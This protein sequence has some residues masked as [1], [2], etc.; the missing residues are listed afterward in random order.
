MWTP[1]SVSRWIF[2]LT[3]AVVLFVSATQANTPGISLSCC[4]SHESTKIRRIKRCFEQ[5]PRYDC[6]HHAFLIMNRR[7]RWCIDPAAQ[8]LQDLIKAGK[9]NCPRVCH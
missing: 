5:T 8:W 1:L 9:L 6:D 7:G 4:F 2:L 3:L